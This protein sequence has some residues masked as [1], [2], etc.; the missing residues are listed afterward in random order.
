[1]NVDNAPITRGILVAT[2]RSGDPALDRLLGSKLLPLVD[3]PWVLRAAE[4]LVALGCRQLDVVLGENAPAVRELLGDGERLG[5][6]IRYHTTRDAVGPLEP[7]WLLA[8]RGDERLWFGT[9]RQI[10]ALSALQGR[11]AGAPSGDGVALVA[12]G[13]GQRVEWT[14]WGCFALRAL[15][16]AAARRASWQS[17]E[18]WAL[19]SPALRRE[20]ASLRYEATT[21]GA[22][23]DA[24]RRFLEGADAPLGVGL[25]A[26]A[27]GLFVSP[28]ARVHA[29]ARIVAPA[30]VGADCVI[31]AGAV[32]GPNAVVLDESAIGEGTTVTESVVLPA[33]RVGP[34]LTLHRAIADS[35]VYIDA[36]RETAL[37]LRDPGLI[38]SAR[39]TTSRAP[40]VPLWH[41]LAAIVACAAA[42]P[43]MALRLLRSQWPEPLPERKHAIFSAAPHAWRA[44]FSEVFLPRLGAVAAG[45]LALTG[46]ELRGAEELAR[47]DSRWRQLYATHRMGLVSESLLL[48]ED[49][50]DDLARCMADEYAAAHPGAASDLRLLAAYAA[51]VLRGPARAGDGPRSRAAGAD[52][53]G[54]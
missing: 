29:D 9:D 1:M 49:G 39:R 2:C 38:G 45:R 54:V 47:L 41:R 50:G 36:Q 7:S 17:L 11:G 35:E 28:R 52:A 42:L 25:K 46:L 13:A 3:R 31:G 27:P 26:R 32:V 20:L 44:H 5:C 40:R 19:R 48:E 10:P 43:W 12:Q 8:G 33:T 4:T 51:R 15:K 16:A 34:D 24:Q 21:A 22:L 53:G 30:Y 6:A 18:E 23:I 37:D 14:G